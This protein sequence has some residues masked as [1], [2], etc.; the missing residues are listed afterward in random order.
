MVFPYKDDNPN[1]LTPVVTIGLVVVTTLVW[2]LVQGAGGEP[3]LTLSVCELG[4]VPSRVFGNQPVPIMS[5]RGPVL[6]CGEVGGLGWLSVF[7]SMFMHGG[8]FHLIGNMWFLWVFGDNVEDSMGHGRFVLFYLVCGVLAA[9]AQMLASPSSP[10]P[11]VG[12]SGAISGVMGAYL[13]LYPKVRVHT[14]IFL[15]FFI[16][17]IEV[18]A[19][20]MLLYWVFLQVIGSL[21]A[22]GGAEAGGVAFLAHIGGFVSGAV[23]IR[24]FAK[25]E[26]VQAHRYHHSVIG[27]R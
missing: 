25:P 17:T 6:P 10:V 18:P 16:T 4:A 1:I 9:M 21:P 5:P 12:A 2:L 24:L 15:G 3:R 27:I 23:L 7:T 13:V 14:L 19:Y 26:L 22:V 20:F 8:W 11:L